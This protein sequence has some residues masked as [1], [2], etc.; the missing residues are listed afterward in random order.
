[1]EELNKKNYSSIC[2]SNCHTSVNNLFEN[3]SKSFDLITS[4]HKICMIKCTDK[5]NFPSDELTCYDQCE[6]VYNSKLI[7]FKEK[8]H[9]EFDKLLN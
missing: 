2:L 5:L 3:F 9:K 4:D 1:M 7:D 6:K 8:L